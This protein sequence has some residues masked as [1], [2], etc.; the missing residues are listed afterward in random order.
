MAGSIAR[1]RRRRRRIVGRDPRVAQL[2]A[3][4]NQIL[5]LVARGLSNG[6]IAA[7]L[8]IEESTVKSHVSSLLEKL[9]LRNRVQAVIYAFEQGLVRV[10]KR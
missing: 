9:G 7:T 4:E 2:T 6:G 8:V 5:L 1:A 10:G 3:R